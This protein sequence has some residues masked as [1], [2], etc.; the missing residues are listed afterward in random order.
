MVSKAIGTMI[1]ATSL[2]GCHSTTY[3]KPPVNNPSDDATIKL[4]QAASSVSDS[5]L[6]IARIE[7]EVFPKTKANT[8]RIPNVFELQTRATVDW[9]GPI[10][11]LTNRLTQAAHYRLRVLGHPPAIPILIS[12]NA[13][14][15][16]IGELLRDI[17]Y[18]AG[19]K[20]SIYVYPK[21]RVIELRY[22]KI[23][24]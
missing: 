21:S 15:E 18:Q 7:K 4:A 22:A 20:A 19:K 9:A 14:D 16:S 23:Y 6:E 24:A 13:K 12:L 10:Q 2:L 1:L 8:L 17:D 5:M 3:I 11:E